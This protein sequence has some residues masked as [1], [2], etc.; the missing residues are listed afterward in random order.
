MKYS[1]YSSQRGPPWGRGYESDFD[2]IL[3]IIVK[4]GNPH[5]I[6]AI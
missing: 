4:N 5:N 1:P 2:I 3:T 6:T